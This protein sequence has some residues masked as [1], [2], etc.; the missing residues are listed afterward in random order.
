MSRHFP[1]WISAYIAYCKG[2]ECPTKFNFWIAASVLAGTLRR[3]TYLDMKRFVWYSNMYIV[4][5]APP[6]IISKT[7]TTGVGMKLLRKVPNINFGPSVV[8][9][10]SLVQT[11]AASSE[12]YEEK[13]KMKVQ[14]AITLEAGELG[15]LLDPKNREMI[16]IFITLW[17]SIEGSFEKK[18]KMAGNDSVANPF[19]N[20]AGCTTP[21]WIAENF[22]QHMIGG[23]FA[24]RCLFVYA[25]K[26]EVLIPY[27]DEHVTQDYD[28]VRD[29][30][31]QDLEHISIKLVGEYKL[32]QEA[33]E[34]GRAW[35]A[36]HH[37][38][39]KKNFE[40]SLYGGY[41]ARKQTHTHKLAMILAASCSDELIIT[42]DNLITAT[43]M[44]TDLEP[45]MNQVFASIGQTETSNNAQ[46]IINIVS[47]HPEGISYM[48][49]YKQV[50]S[51]FPSNRQFE[52]VTTGLC[53][54][55]FLMMRQEGPEMKFR[56]GPNLR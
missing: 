5:V 31:I 3:H 26:K 19:I 52:D 56:P 41:I 12:T 25:D 11:F 8:T 18:T 43:Q 49:L 53:R 13:G 50:H 46:E 47:R 16:D 2:S 9:W 30:L 1:D 20:L 32:S 4:L 45:D 27:P 42:E 34:F 22:P 55:G 14:S 23:G 38:S 7:T 24:S 48:A 40:S 37:N 28:G 36:D 35:Y 29:K 44:V 10:E 6:G 54:S 33:R 17:D 51:H 21:S 15:N 39:S